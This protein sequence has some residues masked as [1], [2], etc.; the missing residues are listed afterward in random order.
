M[1]KARKRGRSDIQKSMDQITSQ[2][3]PSDKTDALISM[4]YLFFSFFESNEF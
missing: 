3:G 2:P 1:K 4:F